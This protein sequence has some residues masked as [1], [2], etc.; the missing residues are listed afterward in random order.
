MAAQ[1]GVVSHS[2]QSIA[3]VS[4]LQSAAAEQA[5]ASTD[6]MGIQVGQM[7]AQAQEL[8]ATAEQLKELVSRFTLDDHTAP[9]AVSSRKPNAKKVASLRRAA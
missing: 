8:A 3:A 2:I 9:A 1:A 6:Q 5:S 4:E 7:S